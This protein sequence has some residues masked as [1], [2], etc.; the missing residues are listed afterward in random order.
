[1]AK[2]MYD[3]I[4][5]IGDIDNSGLGM[6]VE[7]MEN[8]PKVDV[9]YENYKGD[10]NILFT[11]MKNKFKMELFL[12]YGADPNFQNRDE[13]TPLF[14]QDNADVIE[15]LLKY[16]ANPNHQTS[17]GETPLFFVNNVESAK[18]LLNY[19]ADINHKSKSGENAL[20]SIT[21]IDTARF[22][23]SKGLDVNAIDNSGQSLIKSNT[24]AK[25]EKFMSLLLENGF[26]VP[27]QDFI[28]RINAFS[29]GILK[30]ILNN[31]EID[32]YEEQKMSGSTLFYHLH[33]TVNF[34][35]LAECRKIDFGRLKT[36]GESIYEEFQFK[37]LLTDAYLSN[38]LDEKQLFSEIKT[39]GMKK[40]LIDIIIEMNANNSPILSSGIAKKYIEEVL[41]PNKIINSKKPRL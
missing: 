24:V 22:L 32:I 6:I 1:M 8:N 11:K 23:M 9:N 21:D 33:S 18:I 40:P 25:D 29:S 14:Y 15:L 41:K 36:N 37:F 4:S 19:G 13:K 7:F 17:H 26:K 34:L 12:K 10:G 28:L 3:L 39:E 35:T 20:F 38:L 30:K 16:G 2:S 5:K 27:A 31:T